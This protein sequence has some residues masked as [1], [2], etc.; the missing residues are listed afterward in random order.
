[1]QSREPRGRPKDTLTASAKQPNVGTKESSPAVSDRDESPSSSPNEESESPEKLA[2]PHRVGQA[3]ANVKVYELANELA[4]QKKDYLG[5]N[6]DC[7][8]RVSD[9]ALRKDRGIRDYTG[10]H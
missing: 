6:E 7:V 3:E 4:Q 9:A 5:S 10:L 8:H 1:M 2:D